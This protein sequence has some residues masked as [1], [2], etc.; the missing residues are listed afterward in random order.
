[1]KILLE[2]TDNHKS[3]R[4]DNNKCI[5][6]FNQLAQGAQHLSDLSKKY[7]DITLIV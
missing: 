1:M 5:K 6:N 4:I 3:Q 7:Y 2:I